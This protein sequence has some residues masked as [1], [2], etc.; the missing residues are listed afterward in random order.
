M[1]AI[2]FAAIASG[3]D[4][5]LT[6]STTYAYALPARTFPVPEASTWA[7]IL[8][9]FAGVGLAAFRRSTKQRLFGIQD[10][11]RSRNPAAR[12]LE[13]MLLIKSSE[14]FIKLYA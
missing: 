11:R 10:R 13:S 12:S 6:G 2:G 14:Q 8:V 1:R 3:S 4:G 5:S 9:G 7:M